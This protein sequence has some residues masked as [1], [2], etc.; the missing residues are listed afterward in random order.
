MK[1]GVE[2]RR[3]GE[4]ERPPVSLQFAATLVR[5]LECELWGEVKG[6]ASD[7]M[8]MH[9]L[10][11][12]KREDDHDLLILIVVWHPSPTSNVQPPPVAVAVAID[13]QFRASEN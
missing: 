12:R 4:R 5:E 9:T 1:N 11:G 2:R 7:A 3:G 6:Q 10:G 8:A 13:L